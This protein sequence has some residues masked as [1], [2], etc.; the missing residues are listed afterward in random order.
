MAELKKGGSHKGSSL[1]G[2]ETKGATQK[3]VTMEKAMD[4]GLK[5]NHKSGKNL[6]K[7]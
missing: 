5:N 4:K 1:E 7:N 2:R 6:N 3:P